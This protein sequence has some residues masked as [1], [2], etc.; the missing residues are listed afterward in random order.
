MSNCQYLVAEK[1]EK[2]FIKLIGRS[3]YMS[4]ANFK[5]FVDETLKQ[6]KFNEVIIDLTEL[7]FID[8]TNLGILAKFTEYMI[9]NFHRKAIIYST[10]SDINQIIRSVGFFEAFVVLNQLQLNEV[11][12]TQISNSEKLDQNKLSDI[13]LDAHKTLMELNESNKAM[14]SD[15]VKSL[16]K[17]ENK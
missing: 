6:K 7:E 11:E 15:V 13:L 14:F 8:S 16:S 9:D 4:C 2:F 5:D 3:N 1:N 10:N 17:K 12:L